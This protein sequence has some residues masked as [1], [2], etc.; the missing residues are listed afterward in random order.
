MK[1]VIY[2]LRLTRYSDF[3]VNYIKHCERVIDIGDGKCE[4]AYEIVTK[5]GASG[6][7]IEYN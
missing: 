2:K 5:S 1:V 6:H 3:F 4:V 7:V